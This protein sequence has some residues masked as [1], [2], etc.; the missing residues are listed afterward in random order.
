VVVFTD[1]AREAL[2]TSLAA[3]RRFD[4]DAHLRV[5]RQGGGVRAVLATGDEPGDHVIDLGGATIG[6]E[7]GIEGTVD[8]GEHNELSVVGP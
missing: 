3:A 1:S 5:V 6:V 8:A 7:P 4:P 2:L